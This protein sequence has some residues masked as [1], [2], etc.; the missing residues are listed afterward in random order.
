MLK[1]LYLKLTITKII[2]ISLVLRLVS[3]PWVYHGDINATY[4]WGKFASE[5]SWKGYY[6]WLDFGGHGPPDQPMLNIY[7]NWIIRQF[8]LLLYKIFW[9]L[10]IKI[11]LFPSKFMQWYFI[12]GNQY[13]LKLPMIIADIVLIYLCYKFTKSKKIALIL[14]FSLPMIYNSAIWGSGDSIVN[15][16][17]LL[18]IYFLY[19]KKYYL[20]IIVYLC[21]VLYKPS[22][23]I[24]IPIIGV[25]LIKNKINVKNILFSLFLLLLLIFSICLPFTP[26]K[27]NPL[28][29]FFKIMTIKVLPGYMKHVTANA[30]NFWALLFGLKLRLDEIIIA[31]IISAR[32]LSIAICSIFYFYII[33][34]LY[35]NYSIKFLLLSLVNISLVT[36]IFMTRMHERYSFPILIPLLLLSYFDR[37]FIK[38][39]I[40]LSITHLMNVY[41]VWPIPNISFLVNILKNNYVIRSISFINI[42]LTLKL[43]FFNFSIAK[44]NYP[45]QYPPPPKNNKFA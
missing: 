3:W 12:N 2:V 21:S 16:F 45:K 15:L 30:F 20:S 35:K 9:F 23:L 1:K 36:F 40:I 10:N 33:L 41:S 27:I 19:N 29:W 22:L 8:Y 34:K 25:I 39:F 37:R 14:A 7:Y 11:S 24:W 13:L 31:N 4:W 44:T 5:F 26:I 18:C 42:I 38:Y 17:G 28:I 43:V 6:D 32:N